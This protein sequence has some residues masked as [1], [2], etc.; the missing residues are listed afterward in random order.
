ML[1]VSKQSTQKIDSAKYPPLLPQPTGRILI[2][3]GIPSRQRSPA[4]IASSSDY[5]WNHWSLLFGGDLMMHN[6]LHA[7]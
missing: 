1:N 6:I 3:S 7:L 5:D 4:L 2:N